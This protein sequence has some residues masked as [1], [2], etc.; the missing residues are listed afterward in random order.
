MKNKEDI[1]KSI[2]I[3]LLNIISGLV[4]FQSVHSEILWQDNF[5]G[6][7]SGWTPSSNVSGALYP[8]TTDETFDPENPAD[9]GGGVGI[10]NYEPSIYP[11][12]QR[13]NSNSW[14]GWVQNTNSTG[15]ISIQPTGGVNSSPALRVRLIKYPGL[16]NETGLHKWLGNTYYQEVYVQYKIKFG[17]TGNDWW[18]NGRWVSGN[19]VGP[20]ADDGGIIWKLGRVWTGFNPTDIDKTGGQSQPVYDR[21]WSRESNWRTGIWIPSLLADGWNYD[22]NSVFFALSNFHWE[23][24][25]PSIVGGTCDSQNNPRTSN[26]FWEW[27]RFSDNPMPSTSY[28][29]INNFTNSGNPLNPT[30]GAFTEPQRFHTIEMRFK[31]RSHPNNADG[32]YQMW[33]DN[34]EI[35]RDTIHS[36]RPIQASMSTNP[37][38][39][40]I[41]FIRFVDNF[42]KLTENIPD[43]PG[44]MDVFIDDI[45]ISTQR[46]GNSG[47]GVG[48]PPGAP[49]FSRKIEE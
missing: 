16:S 35:T 32:A 9:N 31:N 43:N 4:L 8:W 42:N 2:K 41:N 13:K 34:V 24:S 6:F 37:R 25:C 10:T 30:T 1:M 23:P 38:D 5:N 45:I 48:S 19:P 29:R 20:G 46:I 33:V 36:S 22:K 44:Y 18:W 27:K 49:P 3:F 47:G 28:G 11:L 26:M 21:T 17:S 12:N 7:T 40:G 39:Y 14:N 15:Y